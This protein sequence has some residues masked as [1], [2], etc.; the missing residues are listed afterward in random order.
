MTKL[1]EL[2]DGTPRVALVTGGAGG[3]GSATAR[4]LA[5]HGAKVM[6]TDV[7]EAALSGVVD[8]IR[9]EG[10]VA[11]ATALDVGDPDS[12]QPAGA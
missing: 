3:I 5:A 12:W 2:K 11:M 4:A 9:A 10:G 6:V 1:L 8:A 7:N